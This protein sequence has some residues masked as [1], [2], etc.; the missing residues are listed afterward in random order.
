[1]KC[2]GLC[3]DIIKITGFC[4]SYSK[5]KQDEKNFLETKTKFQNVLRI[6]RMQSLTLEGKIT[7]FKNIAVSKIDYL[8]M[9]IKVQLK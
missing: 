6:S 8:S 1:M 9:M 4:Y 3:K 2:V 5:T 7:V